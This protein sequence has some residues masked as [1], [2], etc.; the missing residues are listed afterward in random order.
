MH[1]RGTFLDTVHIVPEFLAVVDTGDVVPGAE[2]MQS[3]A[4]G[5]LGTFPWVPDW[6]KL[7]RNHLSPTTR[8]SKSIQFSYRW[9]YL[10]SDETSVVLSGPR[11]GGRS[12]PT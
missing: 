11:P 3:L 9:G 1:G 12:L 8:I 7:S 10:R 2:R 5:S 6:L 4:G